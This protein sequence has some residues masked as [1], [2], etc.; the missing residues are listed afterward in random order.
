MDIT[1]LPKKAFNVTTKQDHWNDQDEQ[2][3]NSHQKDDTDI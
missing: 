2:I 1:K 3:R